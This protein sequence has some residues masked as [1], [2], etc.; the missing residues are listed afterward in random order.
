VGLTVITGTATR[1]YELADDF[2]RRGVT[3]ILGGPHITLMP[4]E[5]QQH[6]DSVVVGYAEQTWPRLLHDFVANRLQP[7]YVQD[8]SFDLSESPLPDRS[9]LPAGR[10]LTADVF[11]A[12]RG[13]I[14]DCSF[15]VV[16]A[17]WGRRPWQKP[18]ELVWTTFAVAAQNGRS[19]LT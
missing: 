8:A 19:S 2:R 12:T 15:C 10:Y 6:A 11:E 17:A 18:V 13:C 16:P 5:A 9:V 14:H 3:V 1:A 7:R 4:D